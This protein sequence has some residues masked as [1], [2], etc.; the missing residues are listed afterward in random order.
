MFCPKCGAQNSDQDNFCRACGERLPKAPARAAPVP[1]PPP[2][3][4]G[5]VP[6]AAAGSPACPRCGAP[7]KPGSRFCNRCGQ[8]LIIR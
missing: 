7:V 2:A 5:P 3:S 6:P 8:P 4:S 1:P